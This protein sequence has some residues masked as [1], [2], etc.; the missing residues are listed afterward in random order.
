MDLKYDIS[1]LSPASTP[2]GRHYKDSLW[3]KFTSP[4]DPLPRSSNNNRAMSPPPG[5]LQYSHKKVGK[6]PSPS[7]PREHRSTSLPRQTSSRILNS[8]LQT[9]PSASIPGQRKAKSTPSNTN[10][11]PPLQGSPKKPWPIKALSRKL[12]L[13]TSDE[14]LDDKNGDARDIECLGMKM[15]SSEVSKSMDELESVKTQWLDRLSQYQ[16]HSGSSKSDETLNT[17]QWVNLG[18]GGPESDSLLVLKGQD[19][20]FYSVRKDKTRNSFRQEYSP[21]TSSYFSSEADDNS[22][23]TTPSNKNK[24]VLDL[25]E[26]SPVN[27]VCFSSSESIPS[28]IKT[29]VSSNKTNLEYQQ[30]LNIEAEMEVSADIENKNEGKE[31]NKVILVSTADH[32][33]IS[34]RPGISITRSRSCSR[35]T[36]QRAAT[37]STQTNQNLLAIPSRSITFTIEQHNKTQYANEKVGMCIPMDHK[38][39]EN[40]EYG[41]EDEDDV[42]LEDIPNTPEYMIISQRCKSPSKMK[43][44][45]LQNHTR[46]PP[47]LPLST[48]PSAIRSLLR[49]SRDTDIDKYDRDLKYDSRIAKTYRCHSGEL[50]FHRSESST[51]CLLRHSISLRSKSEE[52]RR[53]QLISPS[54]GS[55]NPH[56]YRYSAG[57]SIVNDPRIPKVRTFPSPFPTYSPHGSPST[58]LYTSLFTSHVTDTPFPLSCNSLLTVYT[59]L[60]LNSRVT[61]RSHP[62][63]LTSTSHL[64]H[65]AWHTTT[66]LSF[67]LLIT[68]RSTSPITSFSP[69]CPYHP[70]HST[71]LTPHV[72]V[73][74]ASPLPSHTPHS[75]FTSNTAQIPSLPHPNPFLTNFPL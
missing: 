8:S 2:G 32:P 62:L 61:N 4:Y 30:I 36:R 74:S 5:L 24:I 44:Q 6:A 51:Q 71:Y 46:T 21:R 42:M 41:D 64:P 34:V 26:T 19:E 58:P 23:K 22:V 59:Y 57:A 1:L 66:R 38:S 69:H 25:Q 49:K 29:P 52:R 17:Q 70:S 40:L 16:I 63:S 47:G 72:T 9:P 67:L 39:S 35:N 65:L 11:H 55:E 15:Q 60:L 7:P 18:V 20:R 13:S 14:V 53:P 3:S 54:T 27:C 56:P 31:K 75:L 10:G 68:P 37:T 48:T 12:R 33:L 45:M 28:P 50:G 73:L 43:G